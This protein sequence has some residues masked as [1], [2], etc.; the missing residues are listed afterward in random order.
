MPLFRRRAEEPTPVRETTWPS[1]PTPAA[2]VGGA[3]SL[4]A[5]RDFVLG[6][7]QPLMPFGMA[8]VDAVGLQLTEDIH[9]DSPVPGY[10]AAAADGY[11]VRA[12]DVRGATTRTPVRLP[13]DG[14]VWIGDDLLPAATARQIRIGQELPVG[15]DCVVP[16]ELTD[17]GTEHVT[18]HAPVLHG[19][20]V[21]EAGSD[22]AEG[23]LLVEKGTVLDTSLVAVLASSGIDKVLVRPRPRVVVVAVGS[24]L[25]SPG[26]SLGAGEK[27]DADSYIVSA[28]A[29]S[30]GAEVWRVGIIGD[31]PDDLREVLADQQIRADLIVVTGGL[32]DGPYGVVGTAV[33]ELGS[34]DVAQ[35]AVRPGGWQ[36]VGILGDDEV[37]VI[38]VP[39]E[40]VSAYVAF[41]AFVRPAILQLMGADPVVQETFKAVAAMGMTST[42][43]VL[44]VCLGLATENASGL[45]VSLVGPRGSKQVS[46]LP[47]ANALVL[48]APE[49][50]FVAAGDEVDVW[51]LDD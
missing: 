37:P 13:V 25:A 45:V 42:D 4:A 40:P 48:L 27:Y 22:I 30:L 9:A 49:V 1:L 26:R 17:G 19:Q 2:D 15:A 41:E 14:A 28:G 11:A 23:V 31:D 38:M 33:K 7:V 10:D 3:R 47:Q 8:L 18:I 16:S 44:E 12:T 35:V 39:G 51:L 21:R 32:G 24:E 46:E 29:K 50:D 20:N 36:G 43:G 5:H 6:L 34:Y